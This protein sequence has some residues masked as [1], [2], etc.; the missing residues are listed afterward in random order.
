MLSIE[1]ILIEMNR[2]SPYQGGAELWRDPHIASEMMNAHL[3][4]NTDAASYKPD[5]IQAICDSLPARMG[6][7]HG[8]HI[9]DLGCGPGLYCRRLAE[10]GFDMTGL[11][12]SENSI[13]YAET[14]CAGKSAAFRLGSYLVPFAE[15]EFNGALLISQDY[16]VLS[17]KVRLTLLHNIHAALRQDGMFALDVPSKTAFDALQRNAAPTWE[18]ADKGLWRPHPYVMISATHFYPD[19]SASCSLYAV[20]DDKASIYRVWQ[21]YFTPD[22]ICRE[23]HEGGFDAV[24]VSTNLL[25]EPWT[26]ESAVLGIVCRKHS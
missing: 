12:W 13:R 7:K 15:E 18:A 4:P 1:S 3:S 9:V 10:Q 6:L 22:S 2:P 25:G 8:A 20:L 5:M 14:L 24:E 17:P 23:L 26:Q 19:I 16:G 21:T 11:D